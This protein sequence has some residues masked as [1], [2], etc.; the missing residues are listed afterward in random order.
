MAGARAFQAAYM[1]ADLQSPGQYEDWGARATRYAVL[2]AYYE[3]TAYSNVHS[4]AQALRS[5]DTAVY[6]YIRNIYNPANRLGAFWQTHLMGGSLDPMAGDGIDEPSALPIDYAGPDGLSNKFS[7]AIAELWKWSNWQKRKGIWTLWGSTMGDVGMRIVDD[8]EKGRVYLSLVDPST[9]KSVDADEYGNTKGYTIEEQRVN[10]ESPSQMATYTE[11]CYR[12]NDLVVWETSLNGKPYAWPTNPAGRNGEPLDM[13]V[14]PY[15]FVPF[16]VTQ[17]IDVGLDWGWSE[18]HA[19]RGKIREIDDLASMLSDQVRK[20]VN[21]VPVFIGAKPGNVSLSKTAD[22]DARPQMGREQTPILYIPDPQGGVDWM[23][24]PID[25]EGV[26]KH[27]IGIIE[28]IERDYPELR[29]DRLR[30][31][32]E[33]SGRALQIARQ[34][35]EAKVLE[36]RVEYDTSLVKAQQMAVAIG[37]WRGYDGYQGFS[38]DSFGRGDLQ[39]TI[40]D[41]PV[42]AMSEMDRLDEKKT[43]WQIV[44]ESSDAPIPVETILADLGWTAEQLAD[45]GTQRMAAIA[46]EQEDTIPE[47]P[48]GRTQ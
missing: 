41:R 10:P 6:Q 5:Q 36:R 48:E 2:W 16:V 40:G 8:V 23:V 21:A 30:A 4:W 47:L 17:H 19:G 33:V 28:E 46:L 44:S 38:L 11:D 1:S 32:G 35:A 42:F 37:G 27:M 20:T 26:L 43:F 13:W 45:Y 14:E 12:D 3:N 18:M 15:G 34:P 29:F 7:V 22:T 31:S 39:H 24:A 9:I 25:Y